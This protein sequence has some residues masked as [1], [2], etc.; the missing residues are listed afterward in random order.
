VVESKVVAA[1]M[2]QVA[3]KSFEKGEILGAYSICL[4]YGQT[5]KEAL[6]RVCTMFGEDAR[7]IIES[8]SQHKCP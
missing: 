2:E 1:W 5:P 6:E 4:D 7:K 8:S 3:Q